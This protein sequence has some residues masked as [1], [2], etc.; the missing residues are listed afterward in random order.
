LCSALINRAGRMPAE[1]M[2][3]EMEWISSHWELLT[4]V[5]VNLLALAVAVAKLT[6][7]TT[8]DE[9]IEKVKNVVESVVK[10]Q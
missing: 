4:A 2:E 3:I 9:W 5:L 8:D 6:P 1:R 10:K 7:S